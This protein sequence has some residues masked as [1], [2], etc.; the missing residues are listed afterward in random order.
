[1][2]GLMRLLVAYHVTPSSR[3]QLARC[4]GGPSGQTLTQLIPCAGKPIVPGRRRAWRWIDRSTLVLGTE[5]DLGPP[6]IGEEGKKREEVLIGMEMLHLLMAVI[7][8]PKTPDKAYKQSIH[9]ITSGVI[10]GKGN[11]RGENSLNTH[12]VKVTN[13]NARVDVMTRVSKYRLRAQVEKMT[14]QRVPCSMLIM[15]GSIK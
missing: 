7:E 12:A 3:N 5:C 10:P 14:T 13:R 11:R 9:R 8:L 1:M 6:I 4:A 2:D 15:S